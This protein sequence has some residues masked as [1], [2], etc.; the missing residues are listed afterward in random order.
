M[1]IRLMTAG[2]AAAVLL[3]GSALVQSAGEAANALRERL[4]PVEPSV[5][6]EPLDAVLERVLTDLATLPDPPDRRPLIESLDTE[7]RDAVDA[8]L[9]EGRSEDALFGMESYLPHLLPLIDA[10][11]QQSWIDR[12]IAT[13]GA[14]FEAHPDWLG[15][16]GAARFHREL[17]AAD[18]HD[19]AERVA[20]AHIAQLDAALIRLEDVELPWAL[21]E[22]RL[23]ARDMGRLDA[24]RGYRDQA[25]AWLL[26]HPN[27]RPGDT[28]LDWSVAWGPEERALAHRFMEILPEDRLNDAIFLPFRDERRILSLRLDIAEG[29]A[30]PGEAIEAVWQRPWS[31]RRRG[32]DD[33][34]D[35]L[36]AVIRDLDG[37]GERDAAISLLNTYQTMMLDSFGVRLAVLWSE[38]GD[39]TRTRAAVQLTVHAD[40][41]PRGAALRLDRGDDRAE[42]DQWDNVIGHGLAD[43]QI[44]RHQ[45]GGWRPRMGAALLACEGTGYANLAVEIQT[46]DDE[47][48]GF[49]RWENADH[50]LA[51]WATLRDA[52]D[53][54]ALEAALWRR[55]TRSENEWEE[56]IV[57]ALL[58][59]DTGRRHEMRDRLQLMALMVRGMPEA[60]QANWAPIY[61]ALV[62]NQAVEL[63]ADDRFATLLVLAATMP[64]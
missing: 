43:T 58:V 38:L 42:R 40:A 63:G 35:L 23:Q 24:E 60:D 34:A 28:L 22:A 61:R 31:E 8:A 16:S 44:A 10:A 64:D 21:A 9:A 3:S 54:R 41:P 52:D 26:D 45:E 37:A 14:A 27:S 15:E 48:D 11:A 53:R 7:L 46:R 62:W 56:G 12:Y 25:A 6:G 20:D 59:M 29:R 51:L 18:Q 49:D 2:L 32:I 55:L 13:S 5:D 39:C 57:P 4:L 47:I 30:T 36:D 33:A 1:S 19:A 17:V 50:W